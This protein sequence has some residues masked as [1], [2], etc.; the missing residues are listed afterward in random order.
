MSGP[1]SSPDPA[2]AAAPGKAA[3][4]GRPR[5]GQGRGKDPVRPDDPREGRDERDRQD[6]QE[7]QA[8]AEPA[9]AQNARAARRELVDHMPEFIAGTAP[10][11]GGSRIRG[12]QHGIAGGAFHGKV[13]L[14]DV[15][16]HHSA[17]AGPAY[18][19]G[20]LSAEALDRIAGAF[21]EGP[22]FAD[23]LERLREE[24]VLVLSGPH[25]SGRKA[26]ASVLLH[27]LG[28][29]T[30]RFLDSGASPA[31]LRGRLTEGAG[32]LVCDLSTSRT[33]PFAHVHLLA[34]QEELKEHGGHLVIT[35]GPAASLA[36]VVPTAWEPPSAA[37]ALCA[38]LTPLVGEEDAARLS[39]DESAA[40]FLEGGHRIGETSAFAD[41]LARHLRGEAS[42]SALAGFGRSAVEKQIRTWFG[43]PELPLRE[44][45][46]LLS[47]AVFDRAPYPLAAEFAD[48]LFIRLKRIAGPDEPP[49]LQVFGPSPEDRLRQVRAQAYEGEEST[50]WG[51]V[52]QTMARYEN[53]L[54]ARTLL[55]EAW[56]RQPSTRPALTDWV[57][58]LADDERPLVRTRSAAATAALAHADLSSAMA[59]LVGPWAASDAYGSRL[60]AAN[61]L[62]MAEL[63]GVSA[64]RHIMNQWCADDR[65][66]GLRWT[67]I[68]A[69]ALLAGLRPELGPEALSALVRRARQEGCGEQ[70]QEHLAASAALLLTSGDT[71]AM[72]RELAVLLR[73]REP[74]VRH[75]ARDAFLYACKELG[76]ADT[77]AGVLD[78]YT[79]AHA[80]WQAA[81]PSSAGPAVLPDMAALWN[82]VLSDRDRTGDALNA[83]CQWVREADRN[84]AAEAA[85]AS[86]LPA[87]AGDPLGRHRIDHLLRTMSD[88]D[89]GP[90][91]P[92]AGRLR[93][94]PG[95]HAPPASVPAPL[96]HGRSTR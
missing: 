1:Q 56:V 89:G 4:G 80:Q 53:A 94:T 69:W 58:G 64:V 83:L 11:F 71:A 6:G 20:T 24:R 81:S 17:P 7:Q 36:D 73:A 38:Q 18:A 16:H 54:T 23:A 78:W 25:S 2:A 72:V 21:A 96:R 31:A 68:R 34:L 62:V 75:L 47:L 50:A 52:P 15:V 35:T 28:H 79:D 51:P 57:R 5:S 33:R 27:R 88:E 59:L 49:D 3:R 74:A 22:V 40:G 85:L 12:D 26:A 46:F 41:L 55:T 19:S 87:L 43:D 45:G 65:R 42:R 14:G 44:K 29:P 70:E 92:V 61:S 32:H 10:A 77:E 66:D 93:R 30:V 13:H 86:L 39:R 67:G 63:L 60:V 8:P 82:D 91:P 9:E 48:P 95:F 37:E 76:A 84:P 90:P